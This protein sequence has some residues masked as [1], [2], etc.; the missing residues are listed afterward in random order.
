M[1]DFEKDYWTKYPLI[2][3]LDEVGRG[4]LAGELVVACVVFPANYSNSRIKDSKLLSE[5]VREELYD[6]IIAS[7]LAYSIEIRSLNDINNS[8]PKAQSRIGMQLALAKLPFEPDL[9][10][11]DFEQIS[12]NLPQI[13]LIKGDNISLSVAAASILAKVTRD[14]M[15]L[16]YSKIYPQYDF[17]NNKGYGTKRHLQALETYG[18]TPLHRIKY[19]PVASILRKKSH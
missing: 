8:N 17:E 1:L 14:R 5:K 15:M 10:I 13:N 16:Q 4:C 6:E 11:T 9:V 2:A 19:K 7:A 3:G 12:T 18:V